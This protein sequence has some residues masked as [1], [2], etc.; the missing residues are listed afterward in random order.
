MARIFNRINNQVAGRR[1]SRETPRMGLH[2]V[3][4]CLFTYLLEVDDYLRSQLKDGDVPSSTLENVLVAGEA[5][6][7]DAKQWLGG[8]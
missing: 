7:E 1:V 5:L 3:V 2:V 4:N 8:K 6:R